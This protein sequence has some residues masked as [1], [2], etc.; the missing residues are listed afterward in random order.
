MPKSTIFERSQPSG[1][2]CD[3]RPAAPRHRQHE[4]CEH[5]AVGCKN[6]AG[7]CG[8]FFGGWGWQRRVAMR[9]VGGPGCCGPHWFPL[10]AFLR[11]VSC[12]H[13]CARSRSR[14]HR[15]LWMPQPRAQ[16]QHEHGSLGWHYSN[17]STYSFPKDAS[18][19]PLHVVYR[20][21]RADLDD[22]QL[23]EH[24]PPTCGKSAKP[25]RHTAKPTR[26]AAKPTRNTTKPTRHTA[27]PTHHVLI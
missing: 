7:R 20:A 17:Q 8:R 4:V 5:W 11:Q 12:A 14:W 6:L 24:P 2:A 23:K 13:E 1:T 19:K 18:G 10:I 21:C 26:H 3:E 16:Q 25:T 15:R 22:L 9:S 27:K